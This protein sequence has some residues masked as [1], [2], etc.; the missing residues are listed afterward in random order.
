MS[1]EIHANDPAVAPAGDL[2]PPSRR[3]GLPRV[4]VVLGAAVFVAAAFLGGVQAQ[5][6]WGDGGSPGGRGNLGR[7]AAANGLGNGNGGNGATT[8]TNGGQAPQGAPGGGFFRSGGFTTGTVKLVQGSTIYVTTQD[9][10]TVKVSVPATTSVTKTVTAKVS[11]IKPG[12]TVTAIGSTSN[13]VVKA[14]TVRVGDLGL[15]TFRR[16][17]GGGQGGQ[18]NGG[19]G[20]QSS[21]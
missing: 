20:G 21:P 14:T 11:S 18:G 19:Q 2:L 8:G 3:K 1:T 17:F 10:N 12:D 5:K 9:G 6:T 16:G 15:P 13:G 7:F 4:T